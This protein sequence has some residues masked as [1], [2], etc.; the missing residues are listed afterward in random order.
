[1]ANSKRRASGKKTNRPRYSA[2][3]RKAYWIGV[4]ISAERHGEGNS[5]LNHRNNSIRKSALKGYAD[6]NLKDV[7][8]KFDKGKIHAK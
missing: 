1:M 8:H 7:S 5:V 6:D 3:E 2:A 4:G